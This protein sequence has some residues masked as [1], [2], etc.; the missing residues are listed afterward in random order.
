MFRAEIISRKRMNTSKLKIT[1]PNNN[2]KRT[3][4]VDLILFN[5]NKKL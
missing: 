2:R 3:V 4:S 5:F 1:V